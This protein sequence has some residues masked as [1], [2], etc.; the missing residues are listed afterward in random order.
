MPGKENTT[1][2]AIH[3]NK[4]VV[5]ILM[6]SLVAVFFM[7]VG[8]SGSGHSSIANTSL[9]LAGPPASFDLRD[10]DGVN[11]VTSVR[12]Q[13]GGTCW[14]HGAMA[15]IEGNL[16]MTGNWASAGEE[17]EPNMA[18][19]H[20]DWWNGFNKHNND[21]TNPPAGGGL[22]VHNGG[23]Y[24]VTSAYLTRGEGAV[25]SPDANDDTEYDGNW[26]DE[27]PERYNSNY[28]YYYVE[29]IEWYTIGDDLSNINTIKY[30]IMEHGVMGTSL[31]YSGSFINNYVHYQPPD[32]SNDPNHAVA[33]VGWDDNKV[34]HAPQPG[35]WLCK[36]SWGSD[37][38]NDGY[39]WISYYDKH[40]CRNPEMGAISFQNVEPLEYGRIYYH[41]YHGWR[42][43]LT[44][45]NEAFN[46]FTAVGNELLTAVSFY[47]A[48]DDAFYHVIV[49]DRFENGELQEELST[50][51]GTINHTGFHTII[52]DTPVRLTADDDFYIYTQLLGGGL[53]YDRTS[54]VPVL[55]G[56]QSPGVIVESS[57]H[58]GES[59]YRKNAQWLDLYEREDIPWPGT[60]N[61][62]IKGLT[63]PLVTQVELEL[64]GGLGITVV[65]RNNGEDVLSNLEWSIELD[66]LLFAGENSGGTISELAPG[67][68]ETLKIPVFGF[69][70]GTITVTVA[71]YATK[72]ADF[73]ILGPFV[74]MR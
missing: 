20:L 40:C 13:Q 66:G 39:F 41:D 74:I 53:P 30:A 52:L 32:N 8:M 61:F 7:P 6:V 45:C 58:P 11:Y 15:A 10:V 67:S 38:G 19:Y 18:E 63:V 34:T 33:I 31:C 29:D 48:V 21:D 69:G 23:D 24:R 4:I 2:M 55:L 25:Y 14:T 35:A 44:D 42:D 37:W 16:L 50:K 57:A 73:L 1:K 47:T 5:G 64:S 12:S 36:N 28:H 22:T 51:H 54:E 17:G 65:V 60:A 9:L 26:Y 3:K 68:E 43:T 46:T 71:E 49:Y 62:C 70:P 72:T 56:S 59:Y 27:P